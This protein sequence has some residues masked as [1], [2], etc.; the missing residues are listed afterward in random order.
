MYTLNIN[1]NVAKL[2]SKAGNFISGESEG[3]WEGMKR[4]KDRLG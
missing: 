1:V 2:G 3:G 4:D